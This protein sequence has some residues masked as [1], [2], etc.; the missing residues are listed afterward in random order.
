MSA[1]FILACLVGLGHISALHAAEEKD[2]LLLKGQTKA[3]NCFI[4][5]E[6]VSELQ[7]VTAKGAQIVHKPYSN[8][9]AWKYAWMNDGPWA[10]AMEEKQRG[11]YEAAA[12]HFSAVAAQGSEAE[13]VYGYYNEGDCRELAGKPAQAVTPFS[14]VGNMLDHRMS[15]DGK[16][17]HGFA[18]ALAGKAAEANKIADELTA[19][20]KDVLGAESRANAIRCANEY[21]NKQY[22]KMKDLRMRSNFRYLEEPE[23][24]FHFGMFYADALRAQGKAA[25]AKSDYVSIANSLDLMTPGKD[26]VARDSTNRARIALGIGLC[27]VETD[28]ASA[29]VELV[30]LDALPYGSI[31]QKCEARYHAG[32]IMWED[33]QAQRKS[34]DFG[35]DAKK[36]EFVKD[37]EKNARL[38]LNASANSGSA[39]KACESAKTMLA[40]IGPDPEE[41]AAKEALDKS[42]K[43]KDKSK[44]AKEKTAKPKAESD[45]EEADKE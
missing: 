25:D 1:R 26:A 32:K 38:L 5:R 39:I 40:T 2:W 24:W 23:T 41:K 3:N 22:D 6:T 15:L 42:A 45:D 36:A 28:R 30:K 18:L 4:Q 21:V 33:A 37:L 13:K 35:R 27:L 8:V 43:E 29:V 17:R 34:G 14:Q 12:D 9:I 31:D 20:G 44:D 11:N 16:Y 7:Y 19:K 10:R